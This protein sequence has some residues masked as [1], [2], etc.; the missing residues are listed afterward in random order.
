MESIKEQIIR[1]R[2]TVI[3]QLVT[4]DKNGNIFIIANRDKK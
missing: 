1:Q 2:L 4:K 3:K